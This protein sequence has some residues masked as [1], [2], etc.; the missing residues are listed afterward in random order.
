MKYASILLLASRVARPAEHSA[1]VHFR[2][3]PVCEDALG[4]SGRVLVA[5]LRHVDHL[6]GIVEGPA[7][8]LGRWI[9]LDPAYHASVLVPRHPVDPLL[10]RHADR[11]V[12]GNDGEKVKKGERS[13][14][15]IEMDKRFRSGAPIAS[16]VCRRRKKFGRTN[17]ISGKI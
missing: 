9:C 2:N 3:R 13:E 11:F 1:V 16:D 8:A 15:K 5:R 4:V 10:L 6:L 7:E 17:Q 12:C 14:K